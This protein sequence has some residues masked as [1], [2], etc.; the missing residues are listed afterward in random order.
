[1]K[2]VAS[3]ALT[4]LLMLAPDAALAQ[5]AAS[6]GLR[7]PPPPMPQKITPCSTLK[8]LSRTQPEL[9]DA[10]RQAATGPVVL[11]VTIE[12]DGVPSDAAIRDSSGAAEVDEAALKVARTW[13]WQPFAAGC[14]TART[15]VRLDV[16][17]SAP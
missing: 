7:P 14:E 1:M 10:M 11:I 15:F 9:T 17:P 4:G 5:A 2:S 3:A 12:P 16:K 8:F 6:P 13:R